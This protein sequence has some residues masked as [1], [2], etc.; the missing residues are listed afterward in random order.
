MK[1]ILAM[2]KARLL[3]LNPNDFASRLL[4]AE[5]IIYI[6]K[7]L[8]A[9]WLYDYAA[10]KSGRPGKHALL[11]SGF[12]SDGFLISKI[13]LE[14]DNIRSLMA[15]QMFW[16]LNRLNIVWPDYL[17]GIPDGATKL[18]Q[19][20][21]GIMGVPTAFLQKLD[22]RITVM[23]PLFSGSKLLIVEDFCTKG[24]GF[25][26]TVIAITSKYSDVEILPYE[27]V[28]VNRGGLK[29]IVVDGVGAFAIIPIADYQ[30]KEWSPE[31]GMCPLCKMGSVAIKP[32]VSEESWRDIT[33]SQL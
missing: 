4:S 15:F 22:G 21:G 23:A 25:K 6:A 10:A 3:A 8:D 5:E 7:T 13:L 2:N 28:I 26:E 18:A 9:F 20:L 1:E 31:P 24:T 17:A 29:E 12:H 16:R 11:K 30:I 19:D 32:K 14:P 27:L 33:T